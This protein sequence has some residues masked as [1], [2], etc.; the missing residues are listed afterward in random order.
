MLRDEPLHY[1]EHARNQR[2]FAEPAVRKAGVVGRVDVARIRPCPENLGE[3][4][5]TAKTGVEH[6][7]GRR[8]DRHGCGGVH[9]SGEEVDTHGTS[10]GGVVVPR[11]FLHRLKKSCRT[12]LIDGRLASNSRFLRTCPCA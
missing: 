8:P 11:V 4:C 3:D 1:D 12:A 5:Q 7:N 10:R 6:E 2:G 9:G